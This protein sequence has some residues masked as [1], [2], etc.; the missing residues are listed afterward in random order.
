MRRLPKKLSLRQNLIVEATKDFLGD[1]RPV[2]KFQRKLTNIALWL[3]NRR[4]GIKLN[5]DEQD[6]V[7]HIRQNLKDDTYREALNFKLNNGFTKEI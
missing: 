5:E 4:K 1:D 7:W 2:K 3:M 6:A